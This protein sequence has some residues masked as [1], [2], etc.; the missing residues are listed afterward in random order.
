MESRQ[1][2]ND[3]QREA[4]T[5][6]LARVSAGSETAL[7]EVY[8]RTSAK[9]FGVCLRILGD[10]GEA[11]DA[12]QEVYVSI[13]RG[14]ESFDPSRASAIAWLAAVARNRAIDRLRAAGRQR[15]AAPIEAAFGL[16]D[17]ADDA[18]A[19]IEAGEERVRLNNCI[20]EL[21]ARQSGAIRSAFFNG[22]TYAELAER[23]AVP[24]ATMKSWVRRGLLRLR[25]C[26]ER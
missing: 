1:R 2:P 5:N 13:W 7:G 3:A 22:F 24:L 20:E 18:I 17:P 26:L 11:E 12:L 15:P 14:A 23:E 9:L 4:L 25:A 21:E 16:P 19:L 10:R 6:A 8:D